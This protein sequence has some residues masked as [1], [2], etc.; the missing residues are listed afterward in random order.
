MTYTLTTDRPAF[1][2]KAS[3][4]LI[5][6][7]QVKRGT[8]CPDG[9]ASMHIARNA[10]QAADILPHSYGE[11]PPSVE[12]Y[13]NIYILDYSFKR[14]ILQSWKDKGIE[15]VILDHHKTAFE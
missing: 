5:I 12:G 2:L 7:H 10:L 14:D 8:D 13:S 9:L 11:E 6:Y 15:L 4:N 3:K 1:L